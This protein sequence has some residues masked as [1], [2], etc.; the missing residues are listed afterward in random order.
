MREARVA[1]WIDSLGRD[2]RHG[3]RMF[4]RRPGLAALAVLTLSLGIG[5][6]AAIFS[7]LNAVLLRP[8]P[9]PDAER[10]VAVTDNFRGGPRVRSEPDGSG[11]CS[12]F[13]K[14]SNHH[15]EGISFSTCATS[16]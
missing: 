2:L 11:K 5:A 13:A 6:N 15:P 3:A 8:L 1:G 10:L 14:R 9:F 7:L 12:T 4:R 16:N